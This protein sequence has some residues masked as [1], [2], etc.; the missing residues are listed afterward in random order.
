[1]K[2]TLETETG[3]KMTIN[4]EGLEPT[5]KDLQQACRLLDE[6]YKDWKKNNGS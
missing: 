6:A 1:M 2:L 4:V 5:L 3:Y